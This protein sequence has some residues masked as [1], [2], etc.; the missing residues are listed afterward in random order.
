VNATDLAAWTPIRV[1]DHPSGPIVDWCHL[2]GIGFD[3]PF[4]TETVQQ[5][6]RHPFRL[7]FRHE[8]PLDAVEA[9]VDERPGLPIAGFV[10]HLSRCGSTLVT[11]ALGDLPD[12]LTVSEP[13]AAGDVLL[14]D[15]PAA[16][17][18]RWLRAVIGALAQPR[19]ATQQACVVKLDA[20]AVFDRPVLRAAFPDVPWIFLHRDPLEVLASH[21]RHR[22]FHMIPGAIPTPQLLGAGEPAPADLDEYGALVLGRLAAAA[23]QHGDDG[24]LLVD[25][26][27]L[28]GALVDAIAPHFGIALDDARQAVVLGATARDAKNPELPYVDDRAAKRAAPSEAARAAIDRWARPAYDELIALAATP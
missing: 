12:V 13:A 11:Q 20:W 15:A 24:L 16:H 28:P 14:L 1:A 2:A 22:G 8:T 3:D 5:A 6:L 21:H 19:S 17:Q 9:L 23:R 26:A 7:L 27:D 10:L 18:A 25:H 4:L